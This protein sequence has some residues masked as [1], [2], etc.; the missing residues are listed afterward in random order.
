MNATLLAIIGLLLLF[1]AYQQRRHEV[2]ASA[3]I[4]R[5]SAPPEA[6][7]RFLP[8]PPRQELRDPYRTW[9]PLPAFELEPEPGMPFMLCRRPDRCTPTR[10]MT[11][12]YPRFESYGVDISIAPT[13]GID[14]PPRVCHP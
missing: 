3:V 7:L 9:P 6:P 10:R 4:D 14:A 12:R 2:W 5:L 13:I 11:R 1:C 8:A